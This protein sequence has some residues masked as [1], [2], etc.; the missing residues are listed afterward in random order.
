MSTSYDCP[1]CGKIHIKA[2]PCQPNEQRAHLSK[3]FTNAQE[4]LKATE[5]ETRNIAKYNL[6]RDG[7]G[8]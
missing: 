2:V 8:R 4:I 5:E 6:W 3:S 1:L 7:H